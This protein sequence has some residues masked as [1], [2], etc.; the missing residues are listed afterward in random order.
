[1]VRG[2]DSSRNKDSYEGFDISQQIGL[3]DAK[4]IRYELKVIFLS[5]KKSPQCWFGVSPQEFNIWGIFLPVS[6][7]VFLPQP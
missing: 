2:E 5:N 7:G 1:M 6:K 3:E 4:K